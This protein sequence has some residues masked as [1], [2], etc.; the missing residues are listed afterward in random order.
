M[1]GKPTLEEAREFI[2]KTIEAAKQ[3]RTKMEEAY[4]RTKEIDLAAKELLDS[5]YFEN[6]SYFLSR[7]IFQEVYRQMVRH[8]ATV[9]EG[10]G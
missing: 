8:I 4:F 5:F 9:M 2:L 6:P 1:E 7:E 10:K 3:F